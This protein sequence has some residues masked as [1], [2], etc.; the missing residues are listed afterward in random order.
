MRSTFHFQ[1]LQIMGPH[2]T[3]E[4]HG[5]YLTVLSNLGG[6]SFLELS[7]EDEVHHHASYHKKNRFVL[8]NVAARNSMISNENTIEDKEVIVEEPISEPFTRSN[9]PHPGHLTFIKP[10]DKNMP[11]ANS[12]N[13][14]FIKDTISLPDLDELTRSM[15]V[16]IHDMLRHGSLVHD[17]KVIDIFDEAQHPFTSD[18]ITSNRLPN[19]ET[20]FHFINT[21]FKVQK[22]P[23]EPG[24]MSMIYFNRV[25]NKTGMTLSPTNWRRLILSCLILSSKVWED[26]AVW[27]VDFIDLFPALTVKDLN[28]LEQQVLNILDFSV[29]IK[30]SEYVAMYFD[31]RKETPERSEFIKPLD[32]TGM[33][34]LE[35][36][37]SNHESETKRVR[38][39]H[40]LS[41]SDLK[42]DALTLSSHQNDMPSSSHTKT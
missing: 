19:V 1:I 12:T 36:R 39:V 41:S 20:I 33:E 3:F 42:K 22:L 9:A 38:L 34:R 23:S 4:V 5:H 8:L 37:T 10:F 21:I 28:R 17:K 25:L 16:F 7:E 11:K 27:N 14:L 2:E 35:L 29:S 31:L 40:S 18:P 26:A 32:E 30:S 24:I 6:P 13:S 15:A